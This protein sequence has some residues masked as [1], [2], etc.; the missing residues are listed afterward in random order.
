MAMTIYDL[1]TPSLTV[2]LDRMQQNIERM[3]SIAKAAGV[4]VRPHAKT[5]KTPQ[6]AM[7]QLAAGSPGLTVAKVGEAEVFVDAGIEDFFIAY[8]L[9]GPLKWER[10]SKLAQRARVRVAADSYEVLEGISRPLSSTVNASRP[11]WR[12]IPASAAVA[13]RR[14]RRCALWPAVWTVYRASNWWGSWAMPG[15]A[16]R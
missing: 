7:R 14:R 6:I 15:R 8:P 4:D 13:C 12:L 5:H 9:W 10:L 16:A 1:D 3:A 2:D 11:V